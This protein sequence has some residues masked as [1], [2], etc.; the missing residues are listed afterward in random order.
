MVETIRNGGCEIE[1]TYEGPVLPAASEA[2]ATR[3]KRYGI[4]ADFIQKME[5]WFKAG[6]KLARRV[7]W[8]IILG[9]FDACIQEES[10][11]EITLAEGM[12][13]DVIGDTHGSFI[14]IVMSCLTEISRSILRSASSV[15]AH[16]YSFGEALSVI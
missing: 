5:E 7:A 15:F 10:L 12:T 1:A 16:R 8:E 9:C 13:C 14:P 3:G 11:A 2:D 6:K 4:D